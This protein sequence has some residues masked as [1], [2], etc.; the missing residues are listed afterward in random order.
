[1]RKIQFPKRNRN[2]KKRMLCFIGVILWVIPLLCVPFSVSAQKNVR[3]TLNETD[4]S[5]PKALELIEKQ[6]GYHFVYNKN[7]ADFNAKVSPKVTNVT[8]TV[9]LDNLFAG[10]GI[11]YEIDDKYIVLKAGAKPQKVVASKVS[12]F[13]K[14][15]NG[16]PLIG[17]TVAV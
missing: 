3:V 9:A 4:I 17:A 13:I 7:I 15:N 10:K 11:T 1:M 14:D 8:I 2:I 5:I 12:G 16:E 6:S